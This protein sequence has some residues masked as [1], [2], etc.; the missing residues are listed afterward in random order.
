LGFVKL[1]RRRA[2][3]HQAKEHVITATVMVR[4]MEM[5]FW[6]EMAEAELKVFG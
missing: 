4:E 1:Y 2:N 6:L 3:L 5:S